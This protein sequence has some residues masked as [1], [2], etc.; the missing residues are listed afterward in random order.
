MI[1]LTATSTA[2]LL[3]KKLVEGVEGSGVRAADDDGVADPA[4]PSAG[5]L[6]PDFGAGGGIEAEPELQ[7]PEPVEKRSFPVR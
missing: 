7:P 5:L 1:T 4:G 6:V 2:Y 3:P